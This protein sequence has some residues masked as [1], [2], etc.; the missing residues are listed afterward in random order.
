MAALTIDFVDVGQGDCS[1]INLP[2]GGFVLIDVG[3]RNSPI[4]DWLSSR[5]Q[6]SR[7]CHAIV[8]THNDVDH[9]GALPSIFGLAR[10]DFGK[11]YML[12]DRPKN[13]EGFQV[14][15]RKALELKTQGRL[16]MERLEVGHEPV[17][18][19][20]A[21]K[22]E[23]AVVF[24]NYEQN[25]AAAGANQTSGILSLKINGNVEVVWAGDSLLENIGKAIG[26]N[27]PR[28]LTGPHHGAPGDW[29]KLESKTA[30]AEFMPSRTFVSVGTF[31]RFF[32]PNREHVRRLA[33]AGCRVVCSQITR[34]CHTGATG[35]GFSV[36]NGNPLLGFPQA[37]TGNPCRGAIRIKRIGDEFAADKWDSLHFERV[38]KLRRPLCVPR[39]EAKGVTS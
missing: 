32:H 22:A 29:D 18:Q 14:L 1:V 38:K 36:V 5:E 37:P 7:R 30:L 24:P 11:L 2:D 39:A 20:A 35:A 27:K 33:S 4:I 31:N 25:I 12:L 23:L 8:L 28:W 17:W 10:S 13:D 16:V 3:P 6:R 19:E 26:T 9:A 34:H 21:L 15:F